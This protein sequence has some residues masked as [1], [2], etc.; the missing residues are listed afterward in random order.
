MPE[1][2]Q[3]TQGTGLF[4]KKWYPE[5]NP[6]T[7]FCL[8]TQKSDTL[9]RVSERNDVKIKFIKERTRLRVNVSDLHALIIILSLLRKF[10]I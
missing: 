10:L 2:S 7:Y 9:L 6:V 5:S 8:L 1:W 4:F 3:K